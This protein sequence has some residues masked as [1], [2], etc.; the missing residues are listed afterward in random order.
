MIIDLS[1]SRFQYSNLFVVGGSDIVIADLRHEHERPGEQGTIKMLGL[2]NLFWEILPSAPKT[3]YLL[4]LIKDETGTVKLNPKNYDKYSADEI[5]DL[6]Q[7]LIV[8]A[9]SFRNDYLTTDCEFYV[10]LI[11]QFKNK[12]YILK[13][14]PP[15]VKSLSRCPKS[16]ISENRVFIP[17]TFKL[18]YTTPTSDNDCEDLRFLTDRLITTITHA[19]PDPGEIDY[20]ESDSG[21]MDER[22]NIE[23]SLNEVG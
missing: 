2:Q 8:D 7:L 12:N 20:C 9:V 15:A 13:D 18:G 19:E 1:K 22:I 4:L 17:E 21:F 5:L 11:P 23:N 16:I 14:Y 10:N 3:P 6:L